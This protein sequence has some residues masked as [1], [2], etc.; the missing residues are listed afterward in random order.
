[1]RKHAASLAAI[2]LIL[3]VATLRAQDQPA[4]SHE[5]VDQQGVA[6]AS[7]IHGDVSSQRGDN[8][9]WVAMTLNTP[10]VAGDRVSTG[11]NSR[12]ELQL[13]WAN[14]LRMSANA[15]ANFTTLDRSNIRI[16]IGQGLT[17]Y[18]VLKG[19]QTN[20]EID[21]PNAAV[22]PLGE[23]EYR[24]LV[25]SNAETQLTV[26][27]GS[28]EVSTPEGSTRV[29]RGQLI[30]I[31]GTDSPQ[32]RTDPAP[33]RD[34]WDSW[35]DDRNRL[36]TSAESWRHTDRYYVGSHDLDSSGTWTEAPDYGQV[37]VPRVDAG[38]APYRD[39][40]WV[41][42]PYY[43]WTW[44]SYEPWGW[45]P[46]HY[47]RW[48]VYGG[49]WAWWPGPVAVY[50]SYYP[51]W[52]PAYVSFFGFGGGGF[53]VGFGFGNW[54]RVG[55]LPCGPGDWY[56]PWY[57]R[58]GGRYGEINARD[59]RNEEFHEGFE[60]LGRGGAHSFSNVNEAFRNE[61][62]RAGI[63]SMAGHEFGRGA[64][65]TH[66]ERVSDAAFRGS[67]MMTGKMPVA[68]TH[69]SYSPTDRRANPS[70]FRNAPS[71]SQRFFS[72]SRVNT[73]PP[74]NNP[75]RGQ[76]A[77]GANSNNSSFEQGHSRP[78]WHA[79]TAPQAGN[80]NS[81]SPG[82]RS[83]G[84]A[85]QSDRARGTFPARNYQSE[86]S[87][88]QGGLEHFN[89]S[90][91][92]SRPQTFDRGSGPPNGSIHPFEPPTSASHGGGYGG[93]SYSY[94]PPLNMRQPI[95]T[96]R[97]GYSGSPRGFN[98][99]PHPNSGQGEGGHNGVSRGGSGGGS[100]G[101]SGGGHSR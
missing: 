65:S 27:N 62:V 57:G 50:P 7:F 52:A 1:M 15:T 3:G 85:A 64:V 95:V 32:Y 48:F 58:W 21:T 14:I 41:W 28:A 44:V 61:R 11:Q 51:I 29:E 8:G 34:D 71:S 90:M 74:A 78:A 81:S 67:S 12:A 76:S 68:P 80:V 4:Q 26:R 30:T 22:R 101:G 59:F 79:F 33:G 13:D 5:P 25:N 69:E 86:P 47:G 20:S 99:S 84:S 2:I 56:H 91:R 100:R 63:S 43:G 98:S 60:P 31:Q 6:R 89:H 88:Q 18:S 66:Q 70:T 87:G 94:R 93:Y 55:W 9:E 23:G 19:G 54:G 39:G 36:I 49:G 92:E 16:Q 83:N 38:W 42:E 96:P 45:A 17:T 40:R 97:G 72:G 35:N 77:I 53:G 24:I 37:W 82:L 73:M 10:I 46:Y 75:G